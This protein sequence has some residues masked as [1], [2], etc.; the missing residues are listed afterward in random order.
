MTVEMVECK[1][2]DSVWKKTMVK[3]SHEGGVPFSL[4]GIIPS[5]LRSGFHMKKERVIDLIGRAN[6]ELVEQMPNP[7]YTPASP[8]L[9]EIQIASFGEEERALKALREFEEKGFK[10]RIELVTLRNRLWHRLVLGPYYKLVEAEKARDTITQSTKFK[11]I[12]IHHY[13]D[14]KIKIMNVQTVPK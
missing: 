8:L 13:P 4:F 6:R 11:P 7:S 12:F 14:K 9:I 5:A 10:P 2:A 3:R 1:N